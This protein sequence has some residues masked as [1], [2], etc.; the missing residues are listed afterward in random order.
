MGATAIENQEKPSAQRFVQ[1]NDP[2]SEEY[3][4]TNDYEESTAYL[5]QKEFTV[6]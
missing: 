2:Q 4:T 5:I 3:F 1:Y 6:I